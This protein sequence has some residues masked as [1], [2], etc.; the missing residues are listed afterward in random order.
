MTTKPRFVVYT[1]IPCPYCDAAKKLLEQR[2]IAFEA[3]DLTG[4]DDAIMA[5]K[6]QL[7]HST[8]PIILF[9]GQLVGGYTELAEL[10]RTGQLKQMTQ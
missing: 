6:E 9:D 3:I 2:G 10:D 1:K 4:Q 7:G 5:L 8:V